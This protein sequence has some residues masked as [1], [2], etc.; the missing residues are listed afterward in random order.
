MFIFL[1][2]GLRCAALSMSR[3]LLISLIF[4]DLARGLQCSG[5]QGVGGIP[6]HSPVMETDMEYIRIG[7]DTS[8]Y[9]PRWL[10]RLNS[11]WAAKLSL[12]MGWHD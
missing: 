12:F 11:R 7:L 3:N 6:R 9:A 5:C 2:P 1:G 10:I 8:H 4:S